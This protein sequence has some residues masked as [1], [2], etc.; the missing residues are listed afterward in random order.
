MLL[1]FLKP[2]VFSVLPAGTVP[3]NPVNASPSSS[4][5]QVQTQSQALS[6]FIPTSVV[7]IHSSLSHLPA[8]TM[9]FP[10][11]SLPSSSVL[12]T[13][14]NNVTVRLMTSSPSGKSLFL[15]T[16]PTDKAAAAAEG[17][18]IWQFD[19]KSWAEQIDELVQAGQYA[20][21]LALLDTLEEAVLSDKVD[22][23]LPLSL[24]S[25]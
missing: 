16:M 12:L 23:I 6:S 17:R 1:A 21:A 10:F 15:V 24:L 19:M 9:P 5:Q 7:Q 8:Q 11:S 13:S 22:Q 25:F 2:Y 3:I 18:T 4:T 20:D 14:T